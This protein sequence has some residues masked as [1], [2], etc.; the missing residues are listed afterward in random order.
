MNILFLTGLIGSLFLVTGAAWPNPKK[1]LHP[2]K[3]RKNQ[4]FAVGNVLMLLYAVLG[5]LGG[6]PIFYVFLES[7]IAV[8]TVFML[9]N[10][11][12]R[13]ASLGVGLAG[14]GFLVWSVFLFEDSSTI[15]FILGLTVLSIGFI[16][17]EPFKRNLTLAL[18][19][20]LIALFSY[21][22]ASPVFFWL[23]AFFALFSAYY[24]VKVKWLR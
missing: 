9:L 11:N 3:A 4:L 15:W 5:Y 24:V 20:A 6:S 2:A 14:L 22:T 12:D 8:S 17:K 7:L 10:A 1:A 13:W 16:L 19:S 18:G 21:L 23:N